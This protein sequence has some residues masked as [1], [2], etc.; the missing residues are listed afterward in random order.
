MRQF[1]HEKM[2]TKSQSAMEFIMLASFMLLVVLGF[3]AVTSSKLLEAREEGNRKIAEDIAE[4]AYSEIDTAQYV[5]DGYSRIFAMPQT[6]NG[7]D[8]SIKIIDSRELVVG[9]LDK[10]HIKFLPSNVTGSI[11]KGNNKISRN[12]GIVSIN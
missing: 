12:N 8:Y 2:H 3:F 11:A 9:Y 6:V 4:L 7:V 5:N 10:E 1:R